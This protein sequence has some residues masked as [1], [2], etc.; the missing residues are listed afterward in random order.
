MSLKDGPGK[1]NFLDNAAKVRKKTAECASDDNGDDDSEYSDFMA[2]VVPTKRARTDSNNPSNDV[3]LAAEAAGEKTSIV[4]ELKNELNEVC[5]MFLCEI[6]F[7]T[8]RRVL[9]K[10]KSCLA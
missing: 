4:D 3:C 8:L 2:D 5:F 10:K 1:P 9:M 6:P 7:L